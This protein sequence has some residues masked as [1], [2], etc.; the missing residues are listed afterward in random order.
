MLKAGFIG[1]GGRG[2]SAHY[3][4]IHRL[5]AQV[6]LAAVGPVK[7]GVAREGPCDV[8]PCGRCPNDCRLDG[9]GILV[10]EEPVLTGVRVK[11]GDGDARVGASHVHE[12]LGGQRTPHGGIDLLVPGPPGDRR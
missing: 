2:Q 4:T 3:P 6:E 1:A 9:L 7:K 10:T 8:P 12:S 11:P 5:A